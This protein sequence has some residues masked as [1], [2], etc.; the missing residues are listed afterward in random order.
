VKLKLNKVLAY[1]RLGEWINNKQQNH[2]RCSTFVMWI[3][4]S[5]ECESLER[6]KFAVLKYGM[7]N[8]DECFIYSTKRS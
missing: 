5:L 7:K 2:K 6:H 8:E 1:F 3:F 4:N